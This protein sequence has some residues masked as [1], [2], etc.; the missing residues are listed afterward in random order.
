MLGILRKQEDVLHAPKDFDLTVVTVVE[1]KK[2]Y[3]F[4]NKKSEQVI[5]FNDSFIYVF[6]YCFPKRC[7]EALDS[8]ITLSTLNGRTQG[9][10]Q[11]Y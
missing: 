2:F 10:L 5:M 7:F 3:H 9:V 4:N 6:I 8:Q 11:W 1:K